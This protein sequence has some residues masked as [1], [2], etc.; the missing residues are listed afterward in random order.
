MK[1]KTENG[2]AMVLVDYVGYDDAKFNEWITRSKYDAF[3][4][5]K[6]NL[7]PK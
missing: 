4:K 2:V 6:K 1:R 7:A 5:E 3:I